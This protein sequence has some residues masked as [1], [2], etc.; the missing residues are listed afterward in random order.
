MNRI[1]VLILVF[2]SMTSMYAQT[3]NVTKRRLGTMI[4]VAKQKGNSQKDSRIIKVDSELIETNAH[5]WAVISI[6]LRND[7]TIVTKRVYP[8]QTPTWV[9]SSK[10]EFI[11]NAETGVKY[12]LQDS[13]I[14]F[15]E[16]II[17]LNSKKAYDFVETYPALP[18][19]VSRVNISSGSEYYVKNQR[20][21]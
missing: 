14:G 3:D 18:K 2:C 10:R 17:V 9:C 4:N 1:I 8:K 6:E 13:S 5:S 7:C 12:F 16:E 11:E 20:V 21:N 15:E 19:S